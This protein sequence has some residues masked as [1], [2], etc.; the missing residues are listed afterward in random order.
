MPQK[1]FSHI[2]IFAKP[3]A[4]SHIDIFEPDFTKNDLYSTIFEIEAGDRAERHNNFN[5]HMWTKSSQDRLYKQRGVRGSRGDSFLGEDG[6]EY[7][8]ARYNTEE[9]GKIASK[10]SIDDIY[11]RPGIDKDPLKFY[12]LHS[13]KPTT[14]SIVVEVAKRLNEKGYNNIPKIYR[15]KAFEH[16][17]IFEQP[18]VKTNTQSREAL[19]F[20]DEDARVISNY[21]RFWKS[22]LNEGFIPGQKFDFSLPEAQNEYE[23]AWGSVGAI[24]GTIGSFVAMSLLTGGVAPA[25]QSLKVLTSIGKI[26]KIATQTA[27]LGRTSR[28]TKAVKDLKTVKDVR[29]RLNVLKKTNQRGELLRLEGSGLLSGSKTYTKLIEE[30]SSISPILGRALDSGVRSVI[31]TGAVGQ[32]NIPLASDVSDRISKLSNDSILGIVGGIANLPAVYYSRTALN[33]VVKRLGTTAVMLPMGVGAQAVLEEQGVVEKTDIGTKIAYGLAFSALHYAT[34]GNSKISTIRKQRESLRKIGYSETDIDMLLKDRRLMEQAYKEADLTTVKLRPTETANIF[35]AKNSKEDIGFID[36]RGV[37]TKTDA[38]KRRMYAV[39]SDANGIE[40]TDLTMNQFFNTFKKVD[41]KTLLQQDLDNV[42]LNTKQPIPKKGE[43]GYKQWNSLRTKVKS[44][45]KRKDI[46]TPLRFKDAELKKINKLI[47]GKESTLDMTLNELDVMKNVYNNKIHKPRTSHASKPSWFEEGGLLSQDVLFDLQK[48]YFPPNAILKSLG[49]K[50]NSRSAI[51]LANKMEEYIRRKEN[52]IGFGDKYINVITK[53]YKLSKEEKQYLP[54][55]LDSE[56]FQGYTLP[57]RFQKGIKTK[58]N[59]EE[60]ELGK[61]IKNMSKGFSDYMFLALA[62]GNSTVKS[63]IDVKGKIKSTTSPIWKA[64]YRTKKGE[65]INISADNLE[66]PGSILLPSMKKGKKVKL[67]TG[68]KITLTDVQSKQ[69]KNFFPR[70]ITKEAK[71]LYDMSATGSSFRNLLILSAMN[72]DNELLA[73]SKKPGMYDVAFESA[74]NKISEQLKHMPE[75]GVYGQ[76]FARRMKLPSRVGI[77]KD[78]VAIPLK[79]FNIKKGDVINGEKLKKVIDIYDNDFQRIYG[80]YTQRVANI[81]SK[82]LTYGAD[83]QILTKLKNQIANEVDNKKVDTW[84]KNTIESQINE[85]DE[86]NFLLKSLRGVWGVAANFGLSSPTSGIKNLLLGQREIFTT[87]NTRDISR[88]YLDIA[89]RPSYWKEITREAGAFNAGTKQLE[90]LGKGGFD[91]LGFVSKLS[92]MKEAEQVNR[93]TALVAGLFTG[94]SALGVLTGAKRGLSKTMSKG[95]ARILLEDTFGFTDEQIVKITKR[96]SF[97]PNEESQIMHMSHAMTQGLAELP[98]V[99]TWMNKGFAKPF[100]LFYRIAYRITENTKKNVYDPLVQQGNPVNLLKYIGATYMTGMALEAMYH[101]LFGL[102]PSQYRDIGDKVFD[103]IERAEGLALFSNAFRDESDSIIDNYMPVIVRL[104]SSAGATALS[105]ATN[106]AKGIVG[107]D[108]EQL[109]NSQQD[110]DKFLK[111]NLVLYNQTMKIYEKETK[112]DI[113]S[114]KSID[115]KGR[116]WNEY[117][118]NTPKGDAESGSRKS[119]ERA[120]YYDKLEKVFYSDASQEE[121]ANAYWSAYWFIVHSALRDNPLQR[122]NP[123]GVYEQKKEAMYTLEGIIEDN[124]KPLSFLGKKWS[125]KIGRPRYSRFV[126][127]LS[128]EEEDEL[129]RL[130]ILHG[131]KLNQFKRAYNS[132]RYDEEG[133]KESKKLSTENILRMARQNLR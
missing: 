83:N 28:L 36:L 107:D 96:G 55:L 102:K 98:F 76:Q 118:F 58:I 109:L 124:Y 11:N 75:N 29:N 126:D 15:K 70:R 115:K 38:D 39:Y 43:T 65:D 4:F 10:W 110:L 74:S 12:S 46:D 97:L 34:T 72:A 57:K 84:I 8:T 35:K 108:A 60:I 64:T 121:K 103:K 82:D 113:T 44:S 79:D 95:R 90:T 85:F 3:K 99:P 92:G 14:D 94:R 61:E 130:K 45:Q 6:K 93:M 119:K 37:R 33:S 40:Y 114:R 19:P 17:N 27:K 132:I 49:N 50:K 117:I 31:T 89:K 111:K 53:S 100:T 63:Y 30:A 9:E 1:A 125:K 87:F 21:T 68:E 112:K 128:K 56:L 127:T 13:G 123:R 25:V 105:I 71:D 32:W 129:E 67:K 42:I 52:L 26:G 88:A 7:F 122:D 66:K 81:A 116:Q 54:A 48:I 51:A 23:K 91:K 24:G 133:L 104:A 16:I 106:T 59:G 18:K 78:D 77:T 2:D 69:V 47:V 5:A 41:K 22:F 62:K 80:N 131:T 120:P 20:I 73:L 101:T 86:P